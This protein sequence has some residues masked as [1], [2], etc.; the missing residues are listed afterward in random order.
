MK[1]Q[2]YLLCVQSYLSATAASADEN[3]WHLLGLR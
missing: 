1:A 2:V 3:G